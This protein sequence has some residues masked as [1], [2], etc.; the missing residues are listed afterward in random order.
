[1][2]KL[3]TER[4]YNAKTLLK[5]GDYSSIRE[6]L[7]RIKEMRAEYKI[8]AELNEKNVV[9]LEGN[10][11]F[12]YFH[13]FDSSVN[14]KYK[15]TNTGEEI[16]YILCKESDSSYYMFHEVKPNESYE[17]SKNRG[18]IE[19]YLTNNMMYQ[20]YELEYYEEPI[21]Y[22]FAFEVIK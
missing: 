3:K 17:I 8:L 20:Q 16:F 1:M 21:I 14:N 22:S 10:V 5:D 7:C 2:G 18:V 15:I 19:F 6:M 9:Q 11:D 12:E 4:E 13:T